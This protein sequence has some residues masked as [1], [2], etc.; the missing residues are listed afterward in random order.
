ME[1]SLTLPCRLIGR[2][3]VFGADDNGSRPFGE[4]NKNDLTNDNSFVKIKYKGK[5][6]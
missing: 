2:T 1:G 6:E 4:A 5:Y 3:S